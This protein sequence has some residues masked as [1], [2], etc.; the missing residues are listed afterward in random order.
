MALCV[1]MNSDGTLSP[2]GEYVSACTGY[3]LL[4]GSE[5]SLVNAVNSAFGVPSLEE[6]TGWFV[7]PFVLVVGLYLAARSAGVIVGVFRR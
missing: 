6:T 2:T 5:Y 1:A 4:S 7:G 3:V